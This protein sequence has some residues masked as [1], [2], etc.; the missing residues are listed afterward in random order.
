MY[1]VLFRLGPVTIHTYGVLVAMGV[2]LALWLVHR[3][4]AAAGLD[5]DRVWSLGV[6]MVLAGLVGAKAWLVV[7]YWE[8]YVKNPREIFTLSTLQSA[9]V[10]Y[11]G[12]VA[13]LIVGVL[14]A[15]ASKLAFLPLA[16][17]YAAPLAA[18]HALGRLGCFT[19]GCCWGKP[20]TVAWAA[21]FTDPY[22]AQ[23]VGTPLGIPLHPVQLYEAFALLVSFG[24]LLVFGARPRPTG[25]SFSA[26]LFLYGLVRFTTE[27]FRGDPDRPMLFGGALSLMQLVSLGLMALGLL[28]WLRAKPQAAPAA[29]EQA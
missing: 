15:R 25:Q 8:Y 28:F 10:F 1:P 24:V 13:A 14:Y 20:A 29:E 11:G 16:D 18:G 26:Y 5:A 7:Q 9:G 4:A 19:A 2:L 3:R 22:A 23:L 17:A 27:F 12:L 6:Y 21:T